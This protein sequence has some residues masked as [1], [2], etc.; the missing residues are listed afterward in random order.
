MPFPVVTVAVGHGLSPP[1]DSAKAMTSSEG[2]P[3]RILELAAR[4]GDRDALV[5]PSRRSMS[6]GVLARGMSDLAAQLVGWGIGRGDAVAWLVA[7]RAQ[8]AMALA[9][10]P[11]CATVV[12]IAASTTLDSLL[13]LLPRVRPK[14][15]IAPAGMACAL[16]QAAS[17]LNLALLTAVDADGPAGAF[18]LALREP[19]H[20]LDQTGRHSADWAII[21][22]TSGS[23]GKPKL[24]P[25]GHRQ[26]LRT[27]FA[28]AATLDIGQ[29]DVSGHVMPLHLSGGIRSSYFMALLAGGAVNVL[30]EAD[31]GALLDRKSVV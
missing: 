19:R 16:T 12:P 18:S 11:A 3:S 22:A 28:M 6:F 29:G 9:A 7:D 20:S 14:A 8:S 1:F 30:P 25:L 2:L 15:V 10:L 24:V 31:V 23:T 17:R 13:G 27:A 5:A 26:L 21:G 4:Q